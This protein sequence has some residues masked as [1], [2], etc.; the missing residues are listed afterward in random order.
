MVLTIF[1]GI[2]EFERALIKERTSAGRQAAKERG[3]FWQAGQ[4]Q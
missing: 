2:A 3:S 4:A 1:A